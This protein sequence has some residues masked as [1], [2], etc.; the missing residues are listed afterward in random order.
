MAV[1]RGVGQHGE[2]ASEILIVRPGAWRRAATSASGACDT[3][4]VA[5]IA[6]SPNGDRVASISTKDKTCILWDTADLSAKGQ[7]P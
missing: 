3:G 4:E 7:V 5:D 2:A 6:V 1:G